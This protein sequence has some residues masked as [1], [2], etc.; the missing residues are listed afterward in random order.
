M[1]FWLQ[2]AVVVIGTSWCLTLIGMVFFGGWY[3]HT[4]PTTGNDRVIRGLMRL[5]WVLTF[6][7]TDY[8]LSPLEGVDGSEENGQLRDEMFSSSGR[9]S[10]VHGEDM[11]T[12]R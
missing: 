2:M 7:L 8:P 9:F 1:L 4:H 10:R 12:R 6:G 11:A 5:L 3:A